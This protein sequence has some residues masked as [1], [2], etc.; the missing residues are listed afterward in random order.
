M[1]AQWDSSLTVLPVARV[2]FPATTEYF[3]GFFLADHMYTTMYTGLEDHSLG[4]QLNWWLEVEWPFNPPYFFSPRCQHT[5]CGHPTTDRR[6][7]ME[8]KQ[9]TR[10][11]IFACMPTRD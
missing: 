6:W 10:F 3:K 8:K 1:M 7:L 5:T 11:N 2:Q 9:K 4:P